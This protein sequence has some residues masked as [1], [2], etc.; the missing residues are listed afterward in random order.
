MNKNGVMGDKQQRLVVHGVGSIHTGA[1]ESVIIN[2]SDQVE[3]WRPLVKY[4]LTPDGS[5]S[6]KI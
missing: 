3:W 6:Q 2:G 1:P 5:V 4:L